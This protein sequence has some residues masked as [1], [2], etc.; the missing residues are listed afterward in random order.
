MTGASGK[1]EE[2]QLLHGLVPQRGLPEG[3]VARAQRGS[4]A[5]VARQKDVS[6][7]SLLCNY[8]VPFT[9]PNAMFK[10]P[11]RF[12][13]LEHGDH[14]LEQAFTMSITVIT[15]PNTMFTLPNTV[16]TLANTVITLPNTVFQFEHGVPVFQ[17]WNTMLTISNTMFKNTNTVFALS[18]TMYPAHHTGFNCKLSRCCS[19]PSAFIHTLIEPLF[20][21]CLMAR[22]CELFSVLDCQNNEEIDN[23]HRDVILS[24]DSHLLTCVVPELDLLPNLHPSGSDFVMTPSPFPHLDHDPSTRVEVCRDAGSDGDPAHRALVWRRREIYEHVVPARRHVFE[25]H[26]GT[27]VGEDHVCRRGSGYSPQNRS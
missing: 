19:W 25:S 18:N 12:Q 13:D 2:V 26:V 1:G 21:S 24:H 11:N 8:F 14:A 10:L 23:L 20:T 7:V 6:V 22:R 16:I 15:L 3:G 27:G 5:G 4:Q 9:L 17:L